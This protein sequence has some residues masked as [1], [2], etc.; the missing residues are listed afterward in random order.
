MTFVSTR[1]PWFVGFQ[2]DSPAS[3]L[4]QNLKEQGFDAKY[5]THSR[6]YTHI[7][8]AKSTTLSSLG[9]NQSGRHG[10]LQNCKSYVLNKWTFFSTRLWTRIANLWLFR[11]GLYL[12]VSSNCGRHMLHFYNIKGEA[13][14]I[15]PW[16]EKSSFNKRVFQALLVSSLW[17]QHLTKLTSFPTDFSQKQIDKNGN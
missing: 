13:C 15:K 16:E 2:R 8:T 3:F 1:N 17:G 5:L 7:F 10:S 11:F 9:C 14:R 12:F 6:N 4:I